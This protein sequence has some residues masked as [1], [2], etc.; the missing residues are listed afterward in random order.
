M[1][2]DEFERFVIGRSV[3]D[4]MGYDYFVVPVRVDGE[5]QE[6]RAAVMYNRLQVEVEKGLIIKVIG[7]G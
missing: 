3:S 2:K 1:N 4:T 6:I 7:W 5:S